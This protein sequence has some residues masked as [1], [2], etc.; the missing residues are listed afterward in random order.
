MSFAK[1]FKEHLK[2]QDLSQAEVSRA[3]GVPSS[4]ISEYCKGTKKPA[5]ANIIHIANAMRLPMD[6]LVGNLNDNELM[7]LNDM[8]K[9]LIDSIR[10][11]NVEQRFKV[12]DY[13]AFIASKST[14]R[15]PPVNQ[16]V[17]LA[18]RDG[19]VDKK[20]EFIKP[21]TKKPDTSEDEFE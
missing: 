19:N 13:A 11:M 7:V 6:I 10:K 16:D 20:R 18:A 21:N 3:S 4:L 2:N 1:L 14:R 8:E 12:Y 5:L 9:K 17:A 15:M